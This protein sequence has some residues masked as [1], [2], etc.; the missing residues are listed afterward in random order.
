MYFGGHNPPHFHAHY[1]G[2]EALVE[3]GT[4]V[5]VAGRLRPRAMGLVV[6]WAS[7]H[8]AELEAAWERAQNLQAPGK[9]D[10]LP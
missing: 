8:Q 1:E 3:I 2:E 6:E 10:P 9:I 4:L 5:V 7:L